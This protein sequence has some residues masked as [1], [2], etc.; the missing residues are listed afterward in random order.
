VL[1]TS[2]EVVAVR[3]ELDRLPD[4]CDDR[5]VLDGQDFRRQRACH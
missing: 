4:A 2:A 5:L 3:A 1:C